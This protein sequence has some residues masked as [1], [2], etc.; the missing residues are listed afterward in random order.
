MN[1]PVPF[2]AFELHL[3]GKLVTCGQFALEA[4]MV[5]LYD[6][7]TTLAARGCGHGRML[8]HHLLALARAR[9]ARHAY[10]QVEADNAPA[11]AIYHHLG[12]VDAYA[13]HYRARDPGAA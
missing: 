9:G 10:L 12:F 5:G 13:Y 2:F 11:R 6:I 1:A 7:Y 8:C 4:D 3:Q